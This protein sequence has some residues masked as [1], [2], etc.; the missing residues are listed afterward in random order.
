MVS[1]DR[2]R[3]WLGAAIVVQ[4]ASVGFTEP[5]AHASPPSIHSPPV[6]AIRESLS[7][8][9]FPPLDETARGPGRGLPPLRWRPFAQPARGLRCGWGRE[10][11]PL[12]RWERVGVRAGGGGVCA[13]LP[14]PAAQ[15]DAK[16]SPREKTEMRGPLTTTTGYRSPPPSRHPSAPPVGAIRESPSPPAFPFWTKLKEGRGGVPSKPSPKGSASNLSPSG[17][18]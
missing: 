15:G 7:P 5:P 6:E 2:V 13:T 16:V 1:S 4:P 9:A 17:G 11:F 3:R 8:P 18:N 14:E 12:S 10:V